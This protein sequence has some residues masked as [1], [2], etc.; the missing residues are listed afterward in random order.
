MKFGKKRFIT[1][2]CMVVSL[3]SIMS[4]VSAEELYQ[5]TVTGTYP[6]FQ[7]TNPELANA[8]VAMVVVCGDMYQEE[9]I[10]YIDQLTTNDEGVAVTDIKMKAHIPDDTDEVYSVYI[11][12]KALGQRTLVATF[13]IGDARQVGDVNADRKITAIDALLVLEL[14]EQDTVTEG[15]FQYA[16]AYADEE[17]N[18]LDALAILQLAVSV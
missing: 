16:N 6:Q 13:P 17:I 7:I 10:V 11:G 12:A 9:D 8:E 14:I 2:I 3:L 4:S 1:Y 18:M 5:V 15:E